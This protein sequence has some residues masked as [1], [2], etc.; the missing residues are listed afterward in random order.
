M[1]KPAKIG[2]AALLLAG[3]V[4][5]NWACYNYE[6]SITAILCG[7][8]ANFENATLT[9]QKSD[10]L[11][12]KIGDESIVLL[13][14]EE[15]TLP[16]KELNKVNVFGW[17]GTNSGFLL[18]GVGSGSSTL[19]AVK[20]ISLLD[21]LEQGG[22][23]YNKELTDFYESWGSA[24]RN[25]VRQLSGSNTYKL[26][27]P[28]ISDLEDQISA[29]QDFS[30]TAIFVLSRCGGENI[31]DLP[32]TYLDI[33]AAEQEAL[34]LVQ[35]S[36]ENVIVLLNTTNTMH[37]G[38]LQNAY[39]VDA[40]MY[41]GITG[42]SAAAAIP[43]IL[44]GEVNP[45]GRL[46][47]IMPYSSA[48]DPTQA[49][50][51]TDS[52]Q[53]A[54]NI[55]FGYKWYETADVEGYFDGVSNDYGEGYDGVVQY[56]FG[57]GLSYTDF[58]WEWD[59]IYTMDEEG[60]KSALSLKNAIAANS[61]D[62]SESIYV[63]V[64]V[65]NEG[66]VAG[67]DVVELYS[68][69]EYISGGI[70]KAHVNLIDFA[71]TPEL[72]PGESGKVTMSFTLY[73]IAAYDAYDKNN[74]GEAVW[75]LDAGDYVMKLMTN[76]HTLKECETNSVTLQV[77]EDIII[78]K[79]T[80]TGTPIENRFTGEGAYLGLQID[81]IE[82]GGAEYMTRND[83]EGTFPKSKAPKATGSIINQ[84]NQALYDEPYED[85]PS[86]T[87][88]ADNGVYLATL[89]DGS[90]ASLS[91][92]NG[93]LGGAELVWDYELMADLIN[94]DSETWDELLDQL[95]VSEMRDLIQLGGFRRVAIESIGKPL[96]VDLDGPAGFNQNTL[97]AT[98]GGEALETESWT[99]YP[100]EALIGC[101]WNK[102]LMFEMGRS[103]GAEASVTHV[104]GWYAPGVNLH[105]NPYLGRNFE[106]YSED[107]VLSGKLAAKLVYGAKT[108]G[109]ICYTKHFVSSDAGS[110]PRGVNTWM[111]EQCL[112]ENV[113][114]PFE[115]IVKE[116][117]GNAM[118]SAFNNLGSVWCGAN[119]GMQIEILRQEWGF[120]G[121]IISDWSQGGGIGG[122]NAR[123]GIRGGND[124]WLNPYNNFSGAVD[125][126]NETDVK[127][128]RIACKNIIY[129]TVDAE[130]TA[131]QYRGMSE[132]DIYQTS[133]QIGFTEQPF[134]W[135][136]P[137]LI[138]L[139]VIA[140]I[141]ILKLVFGKSKEVVEVKN[142]KGGKNS[143]SS[144]NV[145]GG[146]KA[147]SKKKGK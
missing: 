59:S 72:K 87:T 99:A 120:R 24:N 25:S 2:V 94:Y 105:R 128:A 107:G 118:M 14:N 133:G 3:L 18:R 74:N 48:Y 129:A 123:Q 8:G 56:P 132:E 81:A 142:A 73:D 102:D 98:W 134:A 11:C 36:F 9:L 38:F 34:D 104:N 89:A 53:Y 106:Y 71:K 112:R 42:Q 140:A 97:A 139:D 68:T 146:K 13:R 15:N 113:L 147:T 7:T 86:V 100:S 115:I 33:T 45:S 77:T 39:N 63:D 55:Y 85:L 10:E 28:N 6:V 46:A 20:T 76:S 58:S 84:A 60:N 54:E 47:D 57:Y 1:K 144:K 138:G 116:G 126:N 135:W 121:V 62:P 95:T 52:Y 19:S 124:F 49:N 110:N 111:T 64:V 35:D 30:D 17:G 108:N 61:I 27:E 127:A 51:Y 70:E 79:D 29:A 66:E 145:K 136:K 26:A 5:G 22:I 32:A 131:N 31:G 50:I 4:A 67:K 96:Q 117:K 82:Y 83:F 109:L 141:F 21:A 43:K 12:R 114:K 125:F 103:M 90:K 23:E 119:Y 41:V 130:Y 88:G 65:T 137:V 78:D 143:K 40:A 16:L 91:Q 101:C 92:L 75:E 93:N 69:P 44:K 122:M 37:T 80:T